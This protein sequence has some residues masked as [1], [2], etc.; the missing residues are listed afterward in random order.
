MSTRKFRIIL[1]LLLM[2][3]FVSTINAQEQKISLS[4][5]NATL[6]Q[7]FNEIE[8][9]T[10]YSFS[11]REGVLDNRKDITVSAQ[12]KDLLEVLKAVLT[13]RGLSFSIQSK[14]VVII[15]QQQVAAS[16]PV[17]I[18]GKVTDA[19]NEP[20]VGVTIRV[21]NGNEGTTTD[22]VGNYSIQ[23]K[24]KNSELQFCYIGYK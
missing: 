3:G 18:K 2:T 13:P 12:N 8:H 14:S 11:Y 21:K 16:K 24:N 10:D 15:P 22:M 6:R 7:F 9:K 19:T 4:L 20:L 1:L 17:I 5:N 23:L